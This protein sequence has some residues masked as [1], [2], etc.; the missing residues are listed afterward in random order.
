M[1]S[2][3]ISIGRYKKAAETSIPAE[4]KGFLKI[5]PQL[6]PVVV[7]KNDRYD[8]LILASLTVHNQKRINQFVIILHHMKA[9]DQEMYGSIQDK[10]LLKPVHGLSSDVQYIDRYVT[11]Q[12]TDCQSD[13]AQISMAI[14][15]SKY[16]GSE[17]MFNQWVIRFHKISSETKE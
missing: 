15:K 14:Q 16:D 6:N 1:P 5:T 2:S 13:A 4:F 10:P 7:Q 8:L 11:S 3:S 17:E 9:D 12:L